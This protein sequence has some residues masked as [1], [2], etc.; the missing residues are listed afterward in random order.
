MLTLILTPF[1]SVAWY[2]AAWSASPAAF[3]L[4]SASVG[5]LGFLIGR[6]MKGPSE[7]LRERNEAEGSGIN[8]SESNFEVGVSAASSAGVIVAANIGV[9]R[10]LALDSDGARHTRLAREL[11]ET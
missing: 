3:I 5:F 1:V 6:I 10:D 11:P 2:S 7:Y 8:I 4:Y 9:L